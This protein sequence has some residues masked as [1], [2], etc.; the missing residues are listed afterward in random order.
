MWIE[1]SSAHDRLVSVRVLWVLCKPYEVFGQSRQ[2][3]LQS[4]VATSRLR[5]PPQVFPL[6]AN[7]CKD[8]KHALV[9]EPQRLENWRCSIVRLTTVNMLLVLFSQADSHVLSCSSC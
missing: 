1:R 3:S 6:A 7:I 9:N 8:V 4:S 5:L 2:F